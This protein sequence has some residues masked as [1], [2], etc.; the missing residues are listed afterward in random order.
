MLGQ[1]ATPYVMDAGE[2]EIISGGLLAV[3]HSCPRRLTPSVR[4]AL[5]LEGHLYFEVPRYL[6]GHIYL[7]AYICLEGSSL[8]YELDHPDTSIPA[9]SK[10]AQLIFR[11]QNYVSSCVKNGAIDL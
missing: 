3:R 8:V 2:N 5:Y 10:M 1:G 4:R 11:D 9:A 6:E 7:K